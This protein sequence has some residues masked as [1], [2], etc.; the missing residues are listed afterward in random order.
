MNTSVLFV[1]LANICRSPTAQ[2]VFQEMVNVAGA[3]RQIEVDSAGTGASHLGEAPDR[4]AITQ[5]RARGYELSTLQ[6]RQV[7]SD[8][9][10]RFE[11]VL[12]MDKQ[13]LANLELLAPPG[14]CGHL[15][16]FLDFHPHPL[17]DEIPDP[18]Y[19]GNAGF[20]QVLDLVE[21]ASRGLLQKICGRP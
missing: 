11:Y 13:N 16:L 15:G 10:S 21:E 2:G 12:A 14:F 18:F 4:R 8:D 6:A 3:Q 5:A 7:T 9:F 17:L 20:E 19:A 1:C